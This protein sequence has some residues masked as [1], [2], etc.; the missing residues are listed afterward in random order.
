MKTDRGLVSSCQNSGRFLFQ[1]RLITC[2]TRFSSFTHIW[3][4]LQHT[5]H[6]NT[7]KPQ[8]NC[9][10]SVGFLQNYFSP[11]SCRVI[12]LRLSAASNQPP[13]LCGDVTLFPSNLNL[14]MVVSALDQLPVRQY[15]DRALLHL[16]S[17]VIKQRTA[18]LFIYFCML[19]PKQRH[20]LTF[21]I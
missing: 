3:R 16:H 14:L 21:H 8:I 1:F 10:G 4:S 12:D 15:G 9:V 6:M 18:L 11:I 7:F 2:E 5:L 13:R 17:V 20:L 19:L